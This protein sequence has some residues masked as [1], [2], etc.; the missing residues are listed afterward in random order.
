[1]VLEDFVADRLDSLD[2]A[3]LVL[4]EV[5]QE[6]HAC[7]EVVCGTGWPDSSLDTQTIGACPAPAPDLYTYAQPF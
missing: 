6:Q 2:G 7:E 5:L 3:S 1:M 4:E